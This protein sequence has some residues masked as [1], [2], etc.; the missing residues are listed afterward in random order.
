M[1]D[2]FNFE[3]NIITSINEWKKYNTQNNTGVY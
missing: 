1:I 2:Y 3:I